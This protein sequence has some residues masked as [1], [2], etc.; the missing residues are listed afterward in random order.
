M[1]HH[2]VLIGPQHLPDDAIEAV[3][4]V[5]LI[6][7]TTRVGHGIT[8]AAA[9]VTCLACGCNRTPSPKGANPTAATSASGSNLQQSTD[10]AS[11]GHVA[12]GSESGGESPESPKT[13]AGGTPGS[14]APSNKS[15]ANQLAAQSADHSGSTADGKEPGGSADDASAKTQADSA[16]ANATTTSGDGS[17]DATPP[18][19]SRERVVIF[20][21]GGPLVVDLVVTIDGQP[22]RGVR[23]RL[24]DEIFAQIDKD[25]D[26]RP[27][28]K[29]LLDK[30]P[31]MLSER[32]GG[33]GNERAR[34]DFLR[35]ADFGGNGIVD[36]NE[37]RRLVSGM[38][39][40][41]ANF[42]LRGA[43]DYRPF[44]YR[45]SVVWKLL[46]ADQDMSLSA[47]ELA[48]AE[49]RLESLDA[50]DDD[51]IDERELRAGAAMVDMAPPSATGQ[52]SL[53]PP[54]GRMLGPQAKWDSIFFDIDELYARA[55]SIR[56]SSFWLVPGL[57]QWLDFDKNEVVD[58]DEVIGLN[59]C[60]PAVELEANFGETGSL[61]K[62]IFC[63]T[64]AADLGARDDV[65]QPI[66]S[67]LQ[68]AVAGIRLQVLAR[69]VA[70]SQPIEQL[71]AAVL[72]QFDTDKNQYLEKAEVEKSGEFN[73]ENFTQADGDS[74]GKLVAKEIEN[75]IARRR[76]TEGSAI[77]A[78]LTAGTDALF[79]SLETV[80]DGRLN[81]R[82]LRQAAANLKALDDD[83]D[84]RLGP[85]EIST[86]V[87]LVVQRGA[88]AG[89]AGV[90][91][92]QPQMPTSESAAAG[93]DWFARTDINR[94]QELSRRE[95]LGTSEQFDRLDT[96]SDGYL[97]PK[98]AAA[99][100]TSPAVESTESGGQQASETDEAPAGAAAEDGSASGK[101]EGSAKDASAGGKDSTAAEK[102]TASGKEPAAPEDATPEAA[103]P[104]V[105][106]G[107]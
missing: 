84:G 31:A 93:P 23:E 79:A 27:T 90:A 49:T 104:T 63:R 105:K 88:T 69:D 60:S 41:E 107:S 67:G 1:A 22:C 2:H 86:S 6:R 28:W 76:L 102:G 25:R 32:L 74:D 26:G 51:L 95:F 15:D 10:Q 103:A 61:T 21:P 82:E 14:A 54:V 40:A 16:D 73:A 87:A 35:G 47:E 83:G 42:A 59:R 89:T 30:P 46:D 55:G 106:P 19:E 33:L 7:A 62:G 5:G 39:D 98:E 101:K 96:N 11:V 45:R 81:S 50:D 80:R 9:I 43:A 56:Q 34:K 38:E 18:E 91:P 97:D 4:A 77:R 68:L 71:A 44:D 24:L 58:S 29:E 53:V 37:L 52:R 8:L 100:A 65:V 57:F 72:T 99:T 66:P 94:D 78:T 70:D 75:A 48:A 3:T 85:L 36:R 17:T 13:S 12:A 64:V 92:Q 20:T